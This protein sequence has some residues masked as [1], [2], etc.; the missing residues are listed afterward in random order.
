MQKGIELEKFRGHYN[1]FMAVQTI[2]HLDHSE[3]QLIQDVI[4]RDYDPT[5]FTDL[6]CGGCVAK[7]L[8]YAFTL[9]DSQK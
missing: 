9:K 4:R 3:R 7:M 2:N 1:T 6:H 8:V 5:Y